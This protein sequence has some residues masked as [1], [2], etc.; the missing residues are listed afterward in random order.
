MKHAV[1]AATTG[2]IQKL[3]DVHHLALRY[4]VSPRCIQKW[5]EAGLIPYHKLGRRCVRFDLVKCDEALA[6]YEK[7]EVCFER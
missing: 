1:N 7:R 2:G 5:K 6:R 3:V 4:G